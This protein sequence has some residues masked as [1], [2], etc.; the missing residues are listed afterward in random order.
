MNSID[1]LQKKKKKVYIF[2][3]FTFFIYICVMDYV[4]IFYSCVLISM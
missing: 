2:H 1:I 3:L 4:S